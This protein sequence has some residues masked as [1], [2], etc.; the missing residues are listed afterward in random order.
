[1]ASG[2][3]L[4]NNMA[5]GGQS[6][7][8][9]LADL[10]AA[11]G[12]TMY[13]GTGECLTFEFN[14]T[15]VVSSCGWDVSIVNAGG[16]GGG[17]GGVPCGSDETD[18]GCFVA[19]DNPQGVSAV[20]PTTTSTVTV[21]G[22]G[23]H[24]R[25]VDATIAITHTFSSDLDVTLTSPAGTTIVLT[26]DNGSFNDDVFFGT[27]FD[28]DALTPVTDFAYTNGVTAT[29]LVPEGAMA[30]F[31][32]EDPNG[33][34]TLTVTDDAGG[35]DGLLEDFLVC[36]VT[37]P[38]APTTATNMFMSSPGTVFDIGSP[39]IDML[40]VAS[41]DTYITDVNLITDIPHT[42]PGDIEM[43]LT[44]PAG[45]TVVITTDNGGGNDDVFAGTT[46]DDGAG[47]EATEFGYTNGVVATPLIPEGALGAFIG[48]DPNGMWT[49]TVDDDAGGD[50]GTLNSW[51][52]EITTCQETMMVG[53]VRYYVS[54]RIID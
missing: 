34:W 31:Y 27:I 23:T 53:D 18:E 24:L 14:A 6:T 29:P 48:E 52:L 37:A 28:D 50:S 26:T 16:G 21:A 38:S 10:I 1:M 35:D 19:A 39:A 33:V 45:T 13:T 3:P 41:G 8:Q 20:N 25:D 15:T 4:F 40:A 9:F 46:W 42:F 43:T 32:G 47:A 22:V 36:L 51:T 7:V 12:G 44:S 30:A 17:G 11:T 54:R 49:L 2:T 5:G